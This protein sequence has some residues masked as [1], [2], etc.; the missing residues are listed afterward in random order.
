M[1]HRA[2]CQYY[3]VRYAIW[4]RLQQ[5]QQINTGLFHF[6]ALHRYCGLYKLK[7]W[8]NPA[9]NKSKDTLFLIA[10]AHCVSLCHILVILA[11]FQS[12]YYCYICYGD[13]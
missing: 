10:F 9:S 1:N 13:L 3:S 2:N 4:Y 11:L 5:N 7:A 12:F 8:D 6:I